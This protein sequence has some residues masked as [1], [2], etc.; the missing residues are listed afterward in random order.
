MLKKKE[1]LKRWKIRMLASGEFNRYLVIGWAYVAVLDMK[2]GLSPN[3]S[4]DGVI[5]LMKELANADK[6]GG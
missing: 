3:E 4:A 5:E 1:W 2:D 6:S